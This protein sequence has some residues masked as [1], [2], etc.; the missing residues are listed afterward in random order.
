MWWAIFKYAKVILASFIL[1]LILTSST[2]AWSPDQSPAFTDSDVKV[3]YPHPC[4]TKYTN[5]DVDG[6]GSAQGCVMGQN[7]RVAFYFPAQGGI[8]YA[9]SFPFDTTYYRLDICSNTPVCVYAEE[10]DVFV[11]HS[12][13]YSNFARHLNKNDKNGKIHYEVGDHSEVFSLS[14]IGGGAF[15]PN[16]LATSKNGKWVLVELK[17]FGYIRINVQTLEAR[18]IVAPGSFYGY[19]NDPSIEM[20]I[21]N[22]GKTVIITGWRAGLRMYSIDESCGDTLNESTQF[23]YLNGV[24]SCKDVPIDIN[25]YISAFTYAMRPMFSENDKTVSFDAFSGSSPARNITLFSDN[26]ITRTNSDYLALGDSFTSGEGETSDTYYV[27]GAINKCHVSTRSYPFLLASAWNLKASSIACSGATTQ[28]ARGHG[29]KSNQ[30]NQLL[31]IESRLPYLV[32]VGIGGNDAGL[33]GKLKDCLGLDTC[34]WAGTAEHRHRTAREIKN[35][36]PRLKE[37]YQDVKIRTLG[38]VIIVGYPRMI[39]TQASCASVI[40][41]LLNQTERVFMDESI[42]YLN[43]IIQAAARDSGVEYAN[44][45]DAFIGE[46]LCISADSPLMNGIR[47]GDDYPDISSLPFI[48]IIGAES[49]HPKPQGHV[50]LATRIHQAYNNLGFIST[51]MNFGIP[52]V[53]PEPSSYWDAEQFY[54][55]PQQATSFLNKITIKKKDAFEISF[56]ALSFKP[57]SDVVIE[58]HSEVKNLGTWQSAEDGSL[59][60]TL[61]SADYEPGFHSVHAIGKNFTGNEIDTYDFITIEDDAVKSSPLIT[62]SSINKPNQISA[63]SNTNQF[64]AL[65]LQPETNSDPS[66]MAVLG[67]S[68]MSVP[69]QEVVAQVKDDKNLMPTKAINGE[70]AKYNRLVAYVVVIGLVILALVVYVY[71]HQKHPRN[72]N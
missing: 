30:P 26:N 60:I 66:Q 34:K 63:L 59:N 46:E 53:V 69:N 22:D 48:K 40:G 16:T 65:A 36:F 45:E 37:F 38:P 10:T 67:D 14:R 7:T 20:A 57:S 4:P 21:S 52:T 54:L 71:N 72:P 2:H 50:N 13:M 25:A 51:Y 62:T 35:L 44:V 61:S 5:I 41:P 58:L 15:V 32:T 12:G 47:L 68:S 24:A 6:E 49:F 27:G 1:G 18:R 39:S 43:R 33:V 28:T 8:A 55:K 17:S 29:S 9:I 56:P 11:A 3:Y 70:I 64:S 31:E 23:Q 19:G 42:R